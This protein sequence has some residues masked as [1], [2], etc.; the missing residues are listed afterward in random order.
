MLI[1]LVT[2]SRNDF[3]GDNL[4]GVIQNRPQTTQSKYFRVYVG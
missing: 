2:N 3:N 1:R 4:G